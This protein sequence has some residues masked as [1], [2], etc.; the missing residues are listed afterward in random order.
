MKLEHLFLG[1]CILLLAATGLLA[2][3]YR[4]ELKVERERARVLSQPSAIS[5][6]TA[7]LAGPGTAVSRSNAGSPSSLERE[8]AQADSQKKN[9]IEQLRIAEREK[10]MLGG[11]VKRIQDNAQS[12]LP[13]DAAPLTQQQ[14]KIKEAPAIAKI[15]SYKADHGIAVLD[16]GTD[17]GLKTDQVY[18]VRRGPY[19]VARKLVIGE[20]VDANEA[21]AIVESGSLQP[22]EVL[23]AGDEVI[24]WE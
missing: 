19:V 24:K 20:S 18:A 4:T 16:H 15:K 14:I 22:G 17:R 12:G 8:A 23:K 1:I 11:K 2:L 6:A 13:P 21:A 3:H 7:P 10:E 5:N 9:L